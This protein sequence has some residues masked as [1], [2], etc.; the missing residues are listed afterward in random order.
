MTTMIA[1][2]AVY[3][4]DLKP[5]QIT[6]AFGVEPTKA[7]LRGDI[8]N[9]RT[10]AVYDYGC[11]KTCTDESNSSLEEH[12]Q[13]LIKRVAGCIDSIPSFAAEYGFEIEISVIVRLAGESP[14]ISLSKGALE[15]MCALGAS[16][17]IDMYL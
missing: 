11:W 15:W 3:G 1:E 7:W 5:D 9:R 14:D 17:D 16:L 13:L 8:R 12:V 4:D 6:S 10:K 2:L